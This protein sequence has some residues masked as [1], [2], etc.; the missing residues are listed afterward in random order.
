[1]ETDNFYIKGKP[2]IGMIHTNHTDKETSL[3][4]AQREMD[5][6]LKYGIFPLIENYFGDDDDC[7]DILRWM[8]QKHQDKIYGLNILGNFYR[9]FELAEKYG[10]SFIQIDSVCGHL[11]PDLDEEYE[12][13]LNHLRVKTN[14]IVLGGVRFK[15]QPVNSGRTL[16]EDLRIGMK[17]CNAIVCTG[18]GT[19]LTTPVEKIRTFKQTTGDFP[20]IVGAGV[21]IDTIDV[22]KDICDGVIIGSWFKNNHKAEFPVN[23]K[24]VKDFMQQWNKK[25]KYETKDIMV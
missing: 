5:I 21:T 7:E 14:C 19:G 2:V 11:E 1:M 18:E 8:Q 12:S 20:V 17:R 3:Q 13:A 24:Y 10:A 6:Y 4:L 15:Y 9:S 23:E 25:K 22:C 16:S